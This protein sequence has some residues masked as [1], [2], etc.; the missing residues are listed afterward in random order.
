MLKEEMWVSLEAAQLLK[1]LG[2][3]EDCYG[4]YEKLEDGV[5]R[6]W[7]TFQP[8]TYDDIWDETLIAPQVWLVEY[9]LMQNFG[10]TVDYD[11]GMKGLEE[12]LGK[13]LVDV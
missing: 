13:L 7:E 3:N 6:F 4:K 2:F 9:W 12:T 1:Q 11:I 10:E 5:Y 8:V